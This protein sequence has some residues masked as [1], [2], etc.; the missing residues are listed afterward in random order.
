VNE[1]YMYLFEINDHLVNVY[2]MEGKFRNVPKNVGIFK[3]NRKK[4]DFIF[5]MAACANTFLSAN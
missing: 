3:S 5:Q 2:K 4:S 1:K